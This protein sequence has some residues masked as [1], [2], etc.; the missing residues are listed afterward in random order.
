MVHRRSSRALFRVV[1]IVALAWFGP[2][3]AG[4][5]DKDG[6]RKHQDTKWVATWTTAPQNSW[7]GFNGDALV[8]FAFPFTPATATTP[9]S[10]P[11][12]ARNQTLR[13]IVKPDLWG[14]TFRVRLT[15][16]WGSN[17]LTFGRVTIG[18][19]S[20]SGATVAGTNVE[21]KFHGRSFVTVPAGQE[22]WSDPVKV[23]WG[24]SLSDESVPKRLEG[25]N[26]AISMYIPGVEG[27]LSYHNTALVESFLG[28]PNSGDHT[29][30]DDDEAYPYETSS[31]FL[32]D[33]VDVIGFSDT[34]VMVGA[35][36]SSVDGSITTPGNND[37]FL[38]WMSRLLHM[39]YGNHV[40]VVN[41]GIGG[42]TAAIPSEPGQTR[43]LP[44]VLPERFDRDILGVSGVS[45]VLFY[46]GTNDFG[47][48]IPPEQ[49]IASLKSMVDK[50]HTHQINAIGSTL[51]SNVHQAGTTDATY[52]AHNQIND[53]I[54]TSGDFDSTAD[55]YTA[56]ANPNDTVDGFPVLYPNYRTHSDPNGTPDYLHLGRAGAMAEADTLDL[57]FFAPPN[58][59]AVRHAHR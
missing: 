2:V 8:N 14:D 11:P 12:V 43:P 55:F 16:T 19:Q 39:A 5:H 49:S 34:R 3:L 32:V 36:S 58:A 7:K 54:M 23:S 24:T 30:D 42:D 31:W 53:Y 46:A 56:T 35:G 27:T 25:R 41:E 13:M 21:V 47:D 28:A 17:P 40:S 10:A 45:D 26:L 18:L 33:A 9:A 51:I 6:G 38:N 57:G 4:D 29:M 52:T 59:P 37:R 48:H 22:M 15:N 20:F 50:L 1:T 44:Q